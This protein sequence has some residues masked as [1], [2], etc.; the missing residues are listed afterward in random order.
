MTLQVQLVAADVVWSGEGSMV[1][2]APST[3]TSACS[4][5][6]SPFLPNWRVVWCW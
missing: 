5:A 4:R 6:T 2:L 1:S 3:G